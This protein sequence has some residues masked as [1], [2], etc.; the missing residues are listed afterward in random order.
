MSKQKAYTLDPSPEDYNFLLYG[1]ACPDNQY[2]I[3][4][5]V[6]DALG[7]DLHLEE[8]IDLSHR[9]GKDFKF[10]FYSF[11]DEA[12]N[13]E[14]NLIPNRSNYVAQ[15]NNEK[16]GGDLFSLFN[17][18]VDESSKLIPELTKTDYL[19]LIK[20]DEHYHHSYKIAEA[21]KKIPEIITLQEI[22]PDQLSSK[23]NLI[24]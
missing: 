6:N 4:N 14:Y 18:T 20:G 9:M 2:F 24:F 23:S 22:I 5:S 17:E 11:F 12:L 21:L 3:V 1:I 8:Y 7:I 19:L 10:S 16:E 15:E 13:L